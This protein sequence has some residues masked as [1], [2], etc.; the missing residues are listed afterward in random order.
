MERYYLVFRDNDSD[1]EG[2]N[3]HY[4]S[5]VLAT[6]PQDAVEKYLDHLELI[7]GGREPDP[8]AYSAVEKQLIA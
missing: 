3:V 7:R 5:L 2:R 8:E 6:N 4:A 1:A